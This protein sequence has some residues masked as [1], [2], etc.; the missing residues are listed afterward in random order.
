MEQE[1]TYKMNEYGLEITETQFKQR[2]YD[3]KWERLVKIIDFDNAYRYTSESGSTVTLIPE[4]WLTVG[5]YDLM[6]EIVD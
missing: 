3:G 2:A 1:M 4:R 6:M 5:V